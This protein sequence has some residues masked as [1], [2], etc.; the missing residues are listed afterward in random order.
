[1]KVT[2]AGTTADNGTFAVT[3]ICTGCRQWSGVPDAQPFIMAWG[4]DT[5]PLASDD[6]SVR[7]KQHE[8]YGKDSQRKPS[9]PRYGRL[10]FLSPLFAI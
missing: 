1:M 8:G 5:D 4:G 6:L 10:T 7:L 2:V 3:G 9:S